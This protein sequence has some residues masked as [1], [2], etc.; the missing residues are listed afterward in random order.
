MGKA[1]I[2]LTFFELSRHNSNLS[3][4]LLLEDHAVDL[5]MES[6]AY[7]VDDCEFANGKT[8]IG[9]V[10]NYLIKNKYIDADFFEIYGQQHNEIL[11]EIEVLEFD[12]SKRYYYIDFFIYI[13]TL[14]DSI[15]HL[16]FTKY[17]NI[18]I[19]HLLSTFGVFK[20]TTELKN[21]SLFY[22]YAARILSAFTMTSHIKDAAAFKIIDRIKE[23]D[24]HLLEKDCICENPMYSIHFYIYTL[25]YNQTDIIRNTKVRT[26]NYLESIYFPAFDIIQRID[27]WF[28]L[29]RLK[30]LDK[31]YENYEKIIELILSTAIEKDKIEV[32]LSNMVYSLNTIKPGEYIHVI[33]KL[34]WFN[35]YKDKINNIGDNYH[36]IELFNC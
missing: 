2:A 27:I 10:I 21:S 31:D 24:N 36:I 32:Y 18:L 13:H 26:Y 14:S 9:F 20:T 7:K 23:I 15:N 11:K 17:Q 33:N 12:F 28:N 1:G 25:L 16:D 8:G 30:E 22:S 29:N 5:L 34:L 19:N 3:D 35:I 4:K 6:L